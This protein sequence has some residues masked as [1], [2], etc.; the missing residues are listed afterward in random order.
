MENENE[1]VDGAEVVIAQEQVAQPPSR[2]EFDA[3]VAQVRRL[4]EQVANARA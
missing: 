3:L 4:A 1:A 2:E